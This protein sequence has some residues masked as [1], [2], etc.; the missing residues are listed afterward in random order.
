MILLRTSNFQGVT[1]GPIVPSR[2][3]SIVLIISGYMNIKRKKK[4][5]L[6]MYD[7]MRTILEVTKCTGVHVKCCSQKACQSL[8]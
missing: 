2:K 8:F 1:I 3:H 7:G 6:A 5:V 4:S